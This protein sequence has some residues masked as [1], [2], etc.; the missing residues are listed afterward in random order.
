MINYQPKITKHKN[1]NTNKYQFTNFNDQ[2]IKT[3]SFCNLSRL[4]EMNIVIYHA[5]RRQ[6]C[7]LSFVI[8]YFINKSLINLFTI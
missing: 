1:Q 6:V 7:Y 8:Y 3:I 5:R 2:N 4:V